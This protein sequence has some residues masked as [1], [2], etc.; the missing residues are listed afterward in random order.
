MPRLVVPSLALPSRRSMSMSSSRWYGMIRWA[1]PDIFTRANGSR[2]LASSPS[3]SP[4]STCGST[5]T[6]SAM[7]GVTCGYRI[8]EGMRCSLNT[9]SPTMTVWPALLPPW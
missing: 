1:L 7:T 2:P 6:P 8:P 3:S 9:S 4:S 5:T